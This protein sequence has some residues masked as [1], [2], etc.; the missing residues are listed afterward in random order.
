M[1]HTDEKVCL[2]I[3]IFLVCDGKV[4]LAHHNKYDCW[5]GI[6]GHI[7]PGEDP[8]EALYKEIKEETGLDPEDVS[9]PKRS[10]MPEN[11]IA[12]RRNLIT[13]VF[14]D[15]HDVGDRDHVALVYFG[16]CVNDC[17]VLVSEEHRELRWFS[18]DELESGHKNVRQD[19]A[20]YALRALE[21]ADSHD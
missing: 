5:L 6:G 2:T 11:L 20:W 17:E 14:V 10:G 9:I 18:R 4:L 21:T 19:T 13:P 12:N 7:D 3:L 8:D 16:T 1:A 15:R